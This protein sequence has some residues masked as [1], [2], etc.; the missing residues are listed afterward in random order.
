MYN[1]V[2]PHYTNVV[3]NPKISDHLL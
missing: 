3:G 2:K 1:P